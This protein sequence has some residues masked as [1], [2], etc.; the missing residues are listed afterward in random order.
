MLYAA[1][2]HNSND[3]AMVSVI[4]FFICWSTVVAM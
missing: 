1:C 2:L 3:V 4:R